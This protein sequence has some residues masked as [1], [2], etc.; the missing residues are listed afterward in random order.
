MD[1]R[2][3]PQQLEIPV[4]EADDGGTRRLGPLSD[5]ARRGKIKY[6]LGH[7]PKD[8]RIL[9][10]GCA[11]N[12]FKHAAAER[13]YTDVRGLDLFP[14]ADIIGDVWTWKDL[15]LEAHS[16][17][18]IIAFEVIEHGDFS[19][20]FHDL[21]KP[22]GLLCATTPVPRFDP[23]CKVME[24][25]RLLQQRS[26]PHSHLTDLRHLPYF[27][28]VERRIKAVVSQWAILR[29]VDLPPIG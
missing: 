5:V 18:A 26:S 27:E 7:F 1:E 25:M 20:P 3:S 12:W 21:L 19:K 11:D 16:F 29:P 23:V 15:G 8:A 14:P 17:D 22:D 13:G 4:P 9:D 24:A 28:V 6:F 2:S 10:V